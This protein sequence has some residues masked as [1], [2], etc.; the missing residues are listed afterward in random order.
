MNAVTAIKLIEFYSSDANQTHL[1]FSGTSSQLFLILKAILPQA[2]LTWGTWSGPSDFMQVSR[3]GANFEPLEMG[4][5]YELDSDASYTF[6]VINLYNILD[7]SELDI[8]EFDPVSDDNLLGYI[9]FKEV[10]SQFRS[11]Q[12]SSPY[13]ETSYLSCSGSILNSD[14]DTE[15]VVAVFPAYTRKS[16]IIIDDSDWTIGNHDLKFYNL[17]LENDVSEVDT[18]AALVGEVTTGKGII[19]ITDKVTDGDKETNPADLIIVPVINE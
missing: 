15:Y 14:N 16:T 12:F 10:S 8:T 17:T 11:N 4:E 3:D 9:K 5:V 6:K 7:N 13:P 1:T 19:A 2:I 18:L